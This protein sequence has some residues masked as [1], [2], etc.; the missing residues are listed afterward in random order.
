METMC[1]RP[2]KAQALKVNQPGPHTHLVPYRLKVLLL[3]DSLDKVVRTA[4]F[5]DHLTSLHT[6]H[7]DHFMALLSVST[8]FH[9]RHDHVLGGHE[10]QFFSNPAV[11]DRLVDYEAVGY[12]VEKGKDGVGG[13]ECLRDRNTPRP[14]QPLR[15]GRLHRILNQGHLM[16]RQSAHALTPHGVPLVR[17]G[18]AADLLLLIWLLHLLQMRQKA[19]VGR[20]LVRRGAERTQ[21]A[22]DVRVDFAAVC[23]ARYRIRVRKSGHSRDEPVE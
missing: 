10:R 22:E 19:Q 15:G 9:H 7:P 5:F 8:T 4:L 3:P 6:E 21:S 23:L 11:D 16:S 1:G 14:L 2:S 17:H 18:R 13:E 12:V 20:D